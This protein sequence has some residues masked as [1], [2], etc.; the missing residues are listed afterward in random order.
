MITNLPMADPSMESRVASEWFSPGS[1]V[2]DHP[3][4]EE[5]VRV[6]WELLFWSK[7]ERRGSEFPTRDGLRSA[8]S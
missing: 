1:M 3:Q 5:P 8:L 2:S 7:T 6:V 4:Q